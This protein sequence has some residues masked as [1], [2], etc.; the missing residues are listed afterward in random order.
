MRYVLSAAFLLACGSST[1][2]PTSES[3]TNGSQ[4]PSPGDCVKTGCSGTVCVE[5]GNEV[6]TTC[7]MKPEY[8]CYQNATCER[9]ADGTCGWTQ[10]H[11]LTSCLASPPQL[12][13][14][15]DAPQ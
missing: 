8:A 6:V 1:P 3:P 12:D 15:G 9:Q 4:A 5:P 11:E 7:E 2:K 13:N 10:S 14:H